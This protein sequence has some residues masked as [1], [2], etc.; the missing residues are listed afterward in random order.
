MEVLK[1]LDVPTFGKRFKVHTA[2]NVLREECGYQ[3]IKSGNSRMSI[4]S[5]N[6][7]DDTGFRHSSISPAN[8]SRTSKFRHSSISPTNISPTSRFS[9][10]SCNRQCSYHSNLITTAADRHYRRT[11]QRASNSILKNGEDDEED[12]VSIQSNI[13]TIDRNVSSNYDMMNVNSEN[14]NIFL[15]PIIV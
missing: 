4:V 7:S 15:L 14:V 13:P 12:F 11:S 3:V 10:P 5:S 9:N 2:I 8:I 1:E 6:C